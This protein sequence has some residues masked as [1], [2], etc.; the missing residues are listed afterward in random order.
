[1][2]FHRLPSLWA[3]LP[4]TGVPGSAC[5]QIHTENRGY[6]IPPWHFLFRPVSYSA[7]INWLTSSLETP[8]SHFDNQ[9]TNAGCFSRGL[10]CVILRILILQQQPLRQML[11]RCPRQYQLQILS[12]FS[13]CLRHRYKPYETVQE[14][15]QS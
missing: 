14:V 10:G 6:F 3:G 8:Y 5:I 13:C 4:N 11:H 9:S 12:M 7:L 1:M 15:T 2:L